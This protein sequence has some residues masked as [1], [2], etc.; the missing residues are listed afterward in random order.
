MEMESKMKGVGSR[1]M[2]QGLI[3]TVIILGWA[4]AAYSESATEPLTLPEAIAAAIHGN[5]QIEMAN[6][7]LKAADSGV[8][9][10]RSG[11]LPQV[12][13]AETYNTTN[14]PLW[15]FGTKLNQGAITASDFNPDRLNDPEAIGNFNTAVTLSWNLYD[16]GRSWI[17]LQQSKEAREIASLGLT[18][19]RQAVIAQTAKAYV[20]ALLAEENRSVVRQA[21]ETARAHAKVV[22]NRFQ[23]GLTVKSDLLRAQVRIADLEQQLFDAESQVLVAQAM[24]KA[25]M[26]RSDNVAF[27][28]ATPFE[29]CIPTTQTLDWW[30]AK[31]LEARPDLKQ[32][33]IQ[34]STARQEIRR[35]RSG[36][37]PRLALQ[38]SY[39]INSEDFSDTANNYTVGAVLSLNLYSG[40]RISSQAAAAEAMAAKTAA[41]RQG[42]SLQIRVAV[43]RAYYQAQSAW[44]RIQVAKDS[45]AQADEGLRIV[46]NRY[47]NG[48][49]TLVTLLDAQVALQE[50]RTRHFKAMHD[51][52]VARIDLALAGGIID[53]DF[54]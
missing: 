41:M 14:S 52:K 44:Q 15:A 17:G 2:V 34:T 22:N 28:L 30:I 38:G 3:V 11:L 50:A 4:A 31:A 25:T 21:L 19:S 12:N 20:G 10:A 39:E 51:Y 37:L 40:R 13:V 29:K 18:R 46:A 26:G 54:H 27:S 1:A 42:A 53:A 24:L 23:S 5:P 7:Q 47:K 43:Q 49:L 9:Q 35:A 8:T 16:G 45:V 36:H 48:L 33:D 6:K 32:M